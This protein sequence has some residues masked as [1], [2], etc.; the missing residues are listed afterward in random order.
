MISVDSSEWEEVVVRRRKKGAPAENSS[1]QWCSPRDVSDPLAQFFGGPVACD[2]CSN[3]FSIIAADVA[4]TFGGLQFAWGE[5]SYMNNPYSKNDPW[6]DKAIHEM[7]I[8]NVSELV[9]L[10][11]VAPSTAWWGKLCNAAPRNPRLIFTRRLKFIGEQKHGAR[12]DT[13]LKYYGR[14]TQQFE[15]H[16]KHLARWTRWGR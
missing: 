14:R 10:M 15:R 9:T 13:V 7:R 2:P 16:F 8:G 3:P 5:T 11:M 12:F 4:Y 6:A 1:D